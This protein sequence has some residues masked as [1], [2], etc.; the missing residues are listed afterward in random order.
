M[1]N[2]WI[3]KTQSPIGIPSLTHHKSYASVFTLKKNLEELPQMNSIRKTELES[4]RQQIIKRYL[5]SGIC[6]GKTLLYRI[7][8]K[9]NISIVFPPW[10]CFLDH[11]RMQI[12]NF[13]GHQNREVATSSSRAQATEKKNEKST[14]NQV[15]ADKNSCRTGKVWF[16]NN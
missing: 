16:W 8:L 1:E 3:K 13:T 15:L 7:L 4:S 12:C 9:S 5:K 14:S 10:R 6:L 2:T 11:N